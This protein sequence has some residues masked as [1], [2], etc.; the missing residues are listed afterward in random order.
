MKK[1]LTP[2]MFVVFLSV[3]GNISAQRFEYEIGIGPQV[4]KALIRDYEI[5]ILENDQ[6]KNDRLLAGYTFNATFRKK[7]SKLQPGI[8]LKSDMSRYNIYLPLLFPSDI[9]EGTESRWD[10]IYTTYRF[11][12]GL[13][14]RLNLKNFY[15]QPGL[16]YLAAFSDQTSN[17]I[18]LGSE[19]T[20]EEVEGE[21]YSSGSGIAGDIQIGY[22]LGKGEFK[23]FGIA[24]GIQ[25]LF[26]EQTYTDE[27]F[28][29]HWE[30]QPFDMYL[31][32]SYRFQGGE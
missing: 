21:E 8:L 22:K 10:N 25:Y 2:L 16:T 20:T 19:D 7:A 28:L 26:K 27:E 3:Y 32:F 31:L 14:L 23:K 18:Y 9:I 13:N 1:F 30:V 11:G 17:E 4:T 24:A 6:P 15:V 5:G 29:H 12:A